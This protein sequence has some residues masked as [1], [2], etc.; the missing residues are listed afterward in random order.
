MIDDIRV[1]A[2]ASDRWSLEA[3][4]LG[5]LFCLLLIISISPAHAQTPPVGR[6][7]D[8]VTCETDGRQSYALYIPSHYTV[9]KKWP[10]VLCF[11]A[12]ARG[13]LPV[14]RLQTAAERYGYIIA[15]SLNSRNGPWAAN[16]AAADAMLKDVRAHLSI[17]PE[18]I[19]TAGVSGGARVASSIALSGLAKG[20]IACSAGFPVLPKGLPAKIEFGFFGTAGTEDFNYAEMLGLD[21][22]L[23]ERKAPH[24]LV[25]FNGGHQWAS[26]ELLTEAME[27]LELYA[28]RTGARPKEESLIQTLLLKRTSHLPVQPELERW[29][30]LRALAVDFKELAPVDSFDTAARELGSSREV[31]KQ[32]QAERTLLVREDDLLHQLGAAAEDL[33]NGRVLASELRRKADKADDTPERRM[34]RRVIS[35]YSSIGRETVR[36]LFG[37]AEYHQAAALLELAD[38][39]RPGQARTLFDLARAYAWDG[40]KKSAVQTLDRAVA[41]GFSDF[42][43]TEKEPAFAKL[44]DDLTFRLTLAKIRAN[45]TDPAIEMSPVRVGAALE[46]VELRAFYLSNLA[47]TT[48]HLSYLLV[49]TVRHNTTAAEAGVKEGMEVTAIQGR[50]VRGMTD[51]DLFETM[52]ARVKNHIALTVREPPHI[53]EKEIHIPLRKSTGVVATR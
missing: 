36:E 43:G 5:A 47:A 14:E 6:L 33:G 17:D 16:A 10:V 52:T 48:P 13:R 38:L 21:H 49:E 46:S 7:L 51:V 40:D 15:G 4:W 29:R 32:L 20:V 50:R 53:S 8:K 1:L 11:D 27:W 12:S 25:I 42:S 31:K 39:L 26:A 18:R 34:V 41:A 44:R 24:R 23:E 19:Y 9:D 45:A 22:D 28:M 37:K 35:S 2:P 3:V 30:A